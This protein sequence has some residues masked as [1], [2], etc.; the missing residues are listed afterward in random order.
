MSR[1]QFIGTWQL[2]SS[3]LVSD[4]DTLYPLGKDCQGILMLDAAGKL[5]AQLMNSN[6]PN[7]SSND[8]LRGTPEEIQAAYQ[9]YIAFWASYTV[10]EEKAMMSYTV[11]GSLYPNWVGHQQDRFYAFE[12][13]RLILKTT[14]LSLAGKENVVGVL[15]WE[16]VAATQ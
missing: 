13:E 1:Q 15:V 11:E 8:M 14:P 4:G 16:K 6:R 9:G 12:E 2:L 5:N 3:E 10:D 7:F